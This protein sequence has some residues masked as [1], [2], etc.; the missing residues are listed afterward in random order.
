[1][2]TLALFILVRFIALL[3]GVS[4]GMLLYKR[5][6]CQTLTDAMALRA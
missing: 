3:C 1:V 2:C 4:L 6:V 5:G